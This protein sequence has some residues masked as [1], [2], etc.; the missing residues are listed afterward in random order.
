MTH[1]FSVL[2]AAIFLKFVFKSKDVLPSFFFLSS[3]RDKCGAAAVAGFFQVFLSF[4]PIQDKQI[5]KFS[6]L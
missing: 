4:L 1:D 3:Q 6:V 5:F 2:R